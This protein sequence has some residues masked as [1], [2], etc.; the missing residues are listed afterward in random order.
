MKKS[1]LLL[2]IKLPTRHHFTL[3]RPTCNHHQHA[4]AID[5]RIKYVV[6]T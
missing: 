5:T 2:G 3:S 1:G 4:N 6:R